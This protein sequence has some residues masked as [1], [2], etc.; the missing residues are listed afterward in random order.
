MEQQTVKNLNVFLLG[1]AFMLVF[2]AFQT[3]GNV[4]TVILDSAKN[5]TSG[6]FTLQFLSNLEPAITLHTYYK[7]LA[8]IDLAEAHQDFL[9]G[10]IGS[11]WPKFECVHEERNF[12]YIDLT[13]V[14]T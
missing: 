5:T 7:N 9:V 4:Q 8:Q 10:F 1:L 13:I 14:T 6:Q 3:M 12:F 2:A 11:F